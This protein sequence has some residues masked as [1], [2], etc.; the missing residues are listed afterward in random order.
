MILY[1]QTLVFLY[2]FNR[3][4]L[5]FYLVFNYCDIAQKIKNNPERKER[6]ERKEGFYWDYCPFLIVDEADRLSFNSLEELRALYDEYKF[7]LIL[8]GMPGIEKRLSRYAQFYSRIGFVHEFKVLGKDEMKFLFE[9]KWKELGHQFDNQTF[10]DV[11][12]IN[13][14]I[15]ITQGNFR[16]TNRI[17]DQMQRIKEINN[18]SN[19]SK[20]LVD[21]AKK[22]LVIGD[23]L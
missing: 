5:V 15:K 19:I 17:F 7:G 8:M 13:E 18:L 9:Q 20:E 14:I 1:K 3:I 6:K 22:C 2:C 21:A 11:E 4:H 23:F 12:A 16:L 10:I